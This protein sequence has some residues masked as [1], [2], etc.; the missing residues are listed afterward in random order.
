[1]NCVRHGPQRGFTLME[2]LVVMIVIAVIAAT[3]GIQLTSGR[4]S[5]V[6]DEAKRLA[7]LIQSAQEQ[8]VLEG[9]FFSVKF[10][11]G[12]YRFLALNDKGELEELVND[13]LFHGRSFPHGIVLGD[14]LINEK[15]QSK[16]GE[17][18]LL[19]PVG[20]MPPFSID[21][22]YK[23]NSWRVESRPDGAVIALTTDA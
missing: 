4:S 6:A 19:T 2:L 20:T 16:A 17:G 12:G 3:T 13:P 5:V 1:M 10:D 7:L 23:G 9:R 18:I 21:L 11:S 22:E 15:R 14:V 8:S